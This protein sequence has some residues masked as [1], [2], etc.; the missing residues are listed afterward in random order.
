M[1]LK[2]GARARSA[3]G[4]P[5]QQG[6]IQQPNTGRYKAMDRQTGEANVA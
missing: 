2:V 6:R 1:L 3:Y 5:F 4:C